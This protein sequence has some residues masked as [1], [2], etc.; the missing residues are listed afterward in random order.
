MILAAAAVLFAGTA[1]YLLGGGRVYPGVRLAGA[2]LSNMT[3]DQASQRIG[4]LAAE[5]G[6]RR[7]DLR[8][9]GE[10][11]AVSVAELGGTV[12]VRAAADS[13][14]GYGRRGNLFRRLAEVIA[15]RRAPVDLPMKYDF[16]ESAASEFLRAAATNINRDPENAR[17]VSYDGSVVIRPEKPG[18]RLKIEESTARLVAAINSGRTEVDLAV[19]TSAPKVKSSD[20]EGIDGVAGSYSTPYNSWERDRSHNLRVACRA[21]DGTIIKPGGDFSYNQ[22]VGPR[23]R[24]S[25]FRDAKMFVEGRVESGTGGGVCQVSTTVYNA[26]LLA[27]LKILRRS[28]HSRPVVYAPVGRDATV[29][30]NIDLKF[31]NDT[32]APIYISASVG[33]KTVNVTIFGRRHDGRKVAIVAEGHSVVSARTVRQVD[34]GIE[35]GKSVVA[36]AGRSGHR[37]TIYRVVSEGGRVVSRELVSRDVYAPETRIIRVSGG[38]EM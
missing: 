38:A 23:D 35:P 1:A 37:I 12:N 36:Q 29:A 9:A 34:D 27:N 24:K 28:H 20:L 3:P 21:L 30:P 4:L 15:A 8:Y 19:E 16:D 31:R 11:T 7:L 25:G 2:D 10:S 5:A 18:I 32:D 6:S 33:E 22:V 13:A 17:P 26:A 14:F